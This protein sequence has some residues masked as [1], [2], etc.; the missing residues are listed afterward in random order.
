MSRVV[1]AASAALLLVLSTGCKKDPSTPEYWDGALND[2]PHPSS[3]V[4]V[5]EQLSGSPHLTPALLPVLHAHL[6]SEK[7]SQTKAALARVLGKVKDASSV[8]PLL[9]AI[10]PAGASSEAR[11]M[12]REIVGALAQIGDARAVAKLLPLL[13][14][15]DPFLKI[16]TMDALGKLKAQEAV[17]PLTAIVND[18]LSEPLEVRRAI[19]ALG[20]IGDP[21]V[22]PLLVKMMYL[23]RGA[24]SYYPEAGFAL[25]QLGKPAADALVP[26]I[27]GE[28]AAL[29]AWAKSNSVVDAALYSK[30]AQV[31]GD[32]D[33][34][35]AEAPLLARL[36]FN[37]PDEMQKF[38]VRMM[39]AN[40]LGRMHSQSGVKALAG[41]VEE[42]EPLARAEYLR[43]LS[44]AGS[45]DVAG[46]LG[47]SAEKGPWELRELTLSTWSLLAADTTLLDKLRMD[48]ASQVQADCKQDPDIEGCDKPDALVQKRLSALDGFGAA[49]AA[50]QACKQDTAC[51][52]KRLDDANVYVRRRAASELGRHGKGQ[53]VLPLLAKVTEKDPDT[54]LYII[55]AADWLIDHDA[56]AAA[57]AKAQL[58]ALKAQLA[59]ERG[60]SDYV[61]VNEDLRRLVARLQRR[62]S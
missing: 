57:A 8:E 4:Q 24:V 28:D 55:E 29:S 14:N 12:N 36:G 48:E 17:A 52:A 18:G 10:D 61:K 25:F 51:W 22:A 31:L 19:L 32:L 1:Y 56:A 2:A 40:A 54:R 50:Y 3:K 35:R 23:E 45:P 60:K 16:D 33:D 30:A 6:A 62:S 39:A 42:K 43:A 53:D 27:K 47:K 38:L 21:K 59:D 15:P 37:A 20:E 9:S 41:M 44:L 26:V 58:D 49:V 13:K 46:A 7:A 5:L 34:P 11:S